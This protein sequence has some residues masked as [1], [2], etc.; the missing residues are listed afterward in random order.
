[1][2]LLLLL[3]LLLSPLL[4]LIVA[5]VAAV[6]FSYCIQLQEQVACL[7]QEFRVMH[8]LATETNVREPGIIITYDYTQSFPVLDYYYSRV[9]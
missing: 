1:L 5:A 6:N 2:L 3:L 7:K 9:Q 8:E 4:L